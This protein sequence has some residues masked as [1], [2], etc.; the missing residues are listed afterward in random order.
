LGWARCGDVLTFINGGG[1]RGGTLYNFR[2]TT[3][4]FHGIWVSW[5]WFWLDD[6]ITEA[7]M[8]IISPKKI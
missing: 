1:R 6:G 4:A 2:I 5:V 7:K 3:E 8:G